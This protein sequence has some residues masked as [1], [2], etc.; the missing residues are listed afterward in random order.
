M[1]KN[2]LVFC[3]GKKDIYDLEAALRKELGDSVD[4]FP[5]HADISAEDRSIITAP[6]PHSKPRI[7]LS[8]NIAQESVTIPNV[9]LVIIM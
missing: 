5:L 2:V 7:I 6:G 8:T 4:I 1:H 9:T 3:A